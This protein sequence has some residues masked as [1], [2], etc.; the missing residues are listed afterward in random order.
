MPYYAMRFVEGNSLKAAIKDFHAEPAKRIPVGAKAVAFRGLLKRFVDIC[1]AVAFAHS[2]NFVHRD[3][4][5]ANVMLGPFGETLV[6]DWGLARSY[7]DKSAAADVGPNIPSAASAEDEDLAEATV[8]TDS[9]IATLT[10][11]LMGTPAYMSPE[12]SAG[13]LS[14]LGPAWDIYS[15]GAT[16]Y[17]ILTVHGEASRRIDPRHPSRHLSRP[18]IGGHV[19]AEAARSGRAEGDGA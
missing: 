7:Q 12:Q 9:G 11:Q 1:N 19:G 2:R 4:K 3:L 17:E 18:A 10:G 15:L 16:L 13:E 14:T 5:P 6:V 8:A